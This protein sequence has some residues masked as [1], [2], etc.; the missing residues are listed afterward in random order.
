MAMR[1]ICDPRGPPGL[2]K[3]A[4][5]AAPG[6]RPVAAAVRV[7]PRCRRVRFAAH[8][9]LTPLSGLAA[10]RRRRAAARWPQSGRRWLPHAQA[11]AGGQPA[12]RGL[13]ASRLPEPSPASG[14]FSGPPR[15][16]H[17]QRHGERGEQQVVE[18]GAE[19]Q[20]DEADV[21]GGGVAD[22]RADARVEQGR[23]DGGADDDHQRDGRR[24]V[25]AVVGLVS[26]AT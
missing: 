23:A 10:V 12:V 2:G 20:A 6:G 26:P 22:E 17:H 13:A 1:R 19:Q 24:A 25:L 4:H 14:S 15:Q 5:S 18:G 11:G 8:S 16:R 21:P 9:R 7:G 3:V